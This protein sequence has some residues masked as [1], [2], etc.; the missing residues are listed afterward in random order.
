MLLD[1]TVT[2]LD[3]INPSFDDIMPLL[4]DIPLDDIRDP[5]MTSH[6]LG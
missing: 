4:V 1:D 6:T 2:H 5:W 3:D